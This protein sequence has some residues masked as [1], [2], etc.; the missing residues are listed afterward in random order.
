M[1]NYICSHKKIL[2]FITIIVLIIAIII[3]TV[4]NFSS[5]KIKSFILGILLRSVLGYAGMTII[6]YAQ[7][8]NSLCSI[9]FW[10][11]AV[12][13]FA[14]A[15]FAV[16]LID[17]PKLPFKNGDDYLKGLCTSCCAFIA[18][19]QISDKKDLE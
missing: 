6:M 8:K 2:T 11:C 16:L 5:I 12:C 19:V 3:T 9:K 1:Y 10:K 17:F 4:F 18:L 14:I 13:F 15:C 7:V